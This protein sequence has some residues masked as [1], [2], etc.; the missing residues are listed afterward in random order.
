MS[1][2]HTNDTIVRAAGILPDMTGWDDFRKETFYAYM[3]SLIFFF[4]LSYIPLLLYVTI[5]LRAYISCRC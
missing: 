5:P 1:T 2:F 3:G 4:M